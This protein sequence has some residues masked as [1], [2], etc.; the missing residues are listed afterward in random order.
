MDIM[1]LFGFTMKCYDMSLMVK[2]VYA[3]I[4]YREW[5]KLLKNN[6][7]LKQ[8]K[9]SEVCYI[10]GNGPSLNK[11]PLDELEG[12][13]IV[14]NDFWRVA[15]NYTFK[16]TFYLINDNAY[17]I[18]S[19]TERCQGVMNCFPDVPH[20]LTVFMGP[21]VKKQYLDYPG[22]VFFFNNIGRTFKSK[23]SIDF[24]KCTYYTWNVVS[25][26]IQFAIWVGYKEIYLLGCDYSLFASRY[27]THV[28]DKKGVKILNS[29]KLRDM[30]FKYSI[31]T[32]IHYEIAK[33][34]HAHS[35]K[36]VNLT[37]DTLLDAYEIDPRY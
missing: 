23:Y 2:E 24:T 6:E 33:Y 36:I 35:V 4:K 21:V 20:V 8:F 22:K 17:A 25:A 32:H 30:L 5:N 26:A 15:G 31:T 10:C 1:S 12:D 37:A 7:S 28:Y 19:F 11:A 3:R 27:I 29:F 18:P 34:A 14:I 13:T 9:K 16:P